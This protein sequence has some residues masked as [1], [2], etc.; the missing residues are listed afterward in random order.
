M[1]LVCGEA[2]IDLLLDPADGAA[3]PAR[4]LPG[5]SPF[6]VAVGLARLGEAVAFFGGLSRD[7][8]GEHLAGV[9]ARE[10]VEARFA[11]R[12]DHP[13][14]LA[15]VAR[16]PDGQPAYTFH[17]A[18]AA[19]RMVAPA[20]LPPALP[21]AVRALAFGSYTLAVEPVASTYAALAAREAGRR[22][23]SVDPNLRPAVVGDLAGWRAAAERFFRVADIV[24][25]SDEDVAL[26][27][28]LS[29]EAAARMFL[30][31][32][33]ALVVITRGKDGAVAYSER[34]S[35]SVPGRAVAVRDTVG[36]GDTFHAA[37]LARL[38]RGGLLTR[39]ALGALTQE[40]LADLLAYGAAAAALTCSRAGADLP[41]ADE[42]EALLA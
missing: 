6:N 37:L 7:R 14:P 35:A 8:F 30:A 33:A 21:D 27:F 18:E 9:L 15:V 17:G 42:V 2:L 23:I 16:G 4:A 12:S 19:D 20:S 10:G 24:K 22:L 3:I 11:P 31:L 29:P 32:G 28:G 41:R 39:Q 36:A 13:T 1:I 40:A 34:V 25:A 5:G 38:S 26:A